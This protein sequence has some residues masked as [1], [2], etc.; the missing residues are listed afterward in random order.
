M[1]AFGI[2]MGR[3]YALAMRSAATTVSAPSGQAGRDA[4]RYAHR[5]LAGSCGD[6]A[7]FEIAELFLD[8]SA[9]MPTQR[10]D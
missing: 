6:R 10:S 2:S 7:R 3:P 1:L 8:K 5:C 9:K 4:A